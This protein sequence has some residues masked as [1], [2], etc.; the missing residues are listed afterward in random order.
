MKKAVWIGIVVVTIEA[1][2]VVSAL[3][4]PYPLDGYVV[5]KAGATIHGAN[6]TFTNLNTD[7]V[8]YSVSSAAGWYTNGADNFPSGYRNGNIIQYYTV[9]GGYTNT[10][11]HT[12][13]VSEGSH[14]MNITLDVI[15]DSDADGVPDAW[16]VEPN[17]PV[18]YWTDSRG[19]GRLR[20]DMNGDGKL[21]SVDALMILQMA[22]KP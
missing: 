5:D 2:M 15:L 21:S 4:D 20:G 19:R 6:V 16:D 18:G 8:I 22:V 7:E 13:D 12:I 10:T 1:I 17:T 3:Q 14:T 9:F 11:T